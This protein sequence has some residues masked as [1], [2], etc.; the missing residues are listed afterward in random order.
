MGDLHQCGK[1]RDDQPEQK[2]DGRQR[3][4]H[5]QSRE[6]DLPEGIDQQSDGASVHTLLLCDIHAEITLRQRAELA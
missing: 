6:Q 3:D 2:G 1:Q 4:R 5:G